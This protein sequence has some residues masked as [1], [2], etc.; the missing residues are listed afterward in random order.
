MK[1]LRF[2]A[3]LL[4][5]L[6]LL[7]SCQKEQAKPAA[8]LSE[9]VVTVTYNQTRCGDPWPD[10]GQRGLEATV[11]DYLLQKGILSTDLRAT[12]QGTPIMCVSCQC[13]TGV[14]LTAGVRPQ[15]VD[16]VLAMGFVKK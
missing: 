8:E 6:G 15:D 14:V 11:K 1:P 4:G 13:P 12:S 10:P 16:A 5:A 3:G 9:A 7:A 2:T